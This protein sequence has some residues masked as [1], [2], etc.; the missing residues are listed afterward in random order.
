MSGCF[1]YLQEPRFLSS[2]AWRFSVASLV[3]Q[4]VSVPHI[5]P[6]APPLWN[7]GPERQVHPLCGRMRASVAAALGCGTP[8]K[9]RKGELVGG[10]TSALEGIYKS[11]L[12]MDITVCRQDRSTEGP[13]LTQVHRQLHRE[14]HCLA[15]DRSL[16]RSCPHPQIWNSPNPYEVTAASKADFQAVQKKPTRAMSSAWAA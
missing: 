14:S 9:Q 15:S 13:V 4:S 3:P 5:L 16:T 7:S 8:T 12:C 6:E 11:C 1:S 10:F 2:F